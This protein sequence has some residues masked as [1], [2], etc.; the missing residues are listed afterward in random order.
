MPPLF[1]HDPLEAV[2]RTSRP[3][4]W[5]APA[6]ALSVA[7]EHWVLALLALAL[8][9][10]LEGDVRSVLRVFVPFAVALLVGVGLVAVC[11][12]VGR[13]AGWGVRAVPSGHALWAATFAAYTF[14]VYGARWG[15]AAAGLALAGGV[16]RIV[17]GSNGI[18]SVAAGWAVGVALGVAAFEVAARL[19]RVSKVA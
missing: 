10:W 5:L 8:F 19:T 4:W 16:S 13:M 18:P 3:G 14:R 17:L 1:A 6:T 11:W 9:A 12:R 2:Q 7:C 15:G